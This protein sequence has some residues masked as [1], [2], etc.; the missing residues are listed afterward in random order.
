[1]LMFRDGEVGL[2]NIEM[3]LLSTFFSVSVMCEANFKFVP[4]VKSTSPKLVRDITILCNI[5]MLV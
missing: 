4:Q 2:R 3:G 5:L 1:M